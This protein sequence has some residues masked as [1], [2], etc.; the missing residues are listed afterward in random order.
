MDTPVAAPRRHAVQ[1]LDVAVRSI[2][3]ALRAGEIEGHRSEKV[4]PCA[5]PCERDNNIF[6]SAHR[7]RQDKLDLRATSVT[8]S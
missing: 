7:D 1:L 8:Q 6:A 5:C 2:G 4:L 3:Y